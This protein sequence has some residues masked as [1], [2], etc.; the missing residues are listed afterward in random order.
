M[1]SK[2]DDRLTNITIWQRLDFQKVQQ[3]LNRI[4]D[5]LEGVLS[6]ASQME[7]AD[8][9]APEDQAKLRQFMEVNQLTESQAIA[10][11]V[12]AFFSDT[13]QALSNTPSSP[14]N[15]LERIAALEQRL[16]DIS[17]K[18]VT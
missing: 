7:A 12:N 13:P 1:F 15:S 8:F 11:I 10:L 2:E 5:R 16:A 4:T 6:K 17:G 18:L 9:I 14:D 3:R